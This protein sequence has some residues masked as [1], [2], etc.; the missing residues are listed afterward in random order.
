VVAKQEDVT[1]EVLIAS[2]GQLPVQKLLVDSL[3]IERDTAHQRH[4]QQQTEDIETCQPRIASQALQ[5]QQEDTTAPHTVQS[6]CKCLCQEYP[7]TK[8]DAFSAS[9]LLFSD[10][11]PC[12]LRAP[13]APSWPDRCLEKWGRSSLPLSQSLSS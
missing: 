2:A 13:S 10:H 4:G 11:R 8:E 5:H 12:R 3:G 6:L 7:D 9:L 1:R